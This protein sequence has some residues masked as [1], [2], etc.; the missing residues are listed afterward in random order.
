M[1]KTY[2]PQAIEQKWYEEWTASGVFAPEG[3]QSPYCIM[4]PPPNVTGS[5]H[6]GHG[7]QQT[8]MDAL[9]RYHRMQGDATL[10]Q[11]GTDH[12]GI[13]TQ[14]VVER[15]LHLQNQTRHD[16]G[17]EKFVEKVWDWKATSGGRI[18]EQMRRLGTSVDWSRERFT[19]DE[20]LSQAVHKVFV[21]LYDQG[22]IYRGKRLVNWDPV[23][24]TALSDLE[25]ISEEEEGFLWHINYPLSSGDGN[26]T[27]A[28]TRPETLLGDVAVAVHPEDSRYQHLIGHMIDL[29]LT[30]RKIPIIADDYVDP[31][32]GSGCVKITPA[33]DFNDYAIGQRH[34]LPSISILTKDAKIN[35]HAPEAYQ[36]L[37][38]FEA[39]KQVLAD[40]ENL[41]LLAKTEKH[42]LNVP[43]G[44]KSEVIVE[45]ML[46]DQWYVKIA[47]LAEPAI[48]AV[49]DG[50]IK[51]VP[52]NWTK[53][54]YQWMENIEDWCISRQLWWGHRIPAWYDENNNIY[55]GYNEKHIRQKYQ[56]SDDVNLKQD[57]DVLDT[58]FSS[59][60]WPFSTLG[61]PDKSEFIKAFYPT[62]V[63]VTGFDIIFFWVARMIMMGLK[64]TGEVPFREVYITGLIRDA[65][66]HKMSKSKGNVLDP[67]DI[68]DGIGLEDLLAKRTQNLV[69]GSQLDEIKQQTIDE[70]PNGINPH[71]TDALRFTYCAL[72]T[73]GR[74]IR[75]DM[76]RV[77][78]Y[79]NFCNKLWN[80]TRYV[81]MNTEEEASDLGD[82]PI[83]YSAADRWI[84]AELQTCIEQ[85]H[86][87]FK[88]YRFDLLC[89][90]LYDFIWR[91][92]CDWYLELSKP[93][94][95]DD[96]FM[97][98]LKRG[99]RQTLLTV[100]ETCLRLLHPM[101]PFITE[102]IWQKVSKV[103]GISGETI[104]TQPYPTANDKLI[105]TDITAQIAWLKH[106]IIEIRTIRSEMNIK[107][108][109]II[110]VYF[111]KGDANDKARVEQFKDYLIKLAK[112]EGLTWL[113]PNTPKPQAATALLHNLEILI[114]MAGLI[115]K[116][117]ETERLNREISKS[118]KDLE[119]IMGK[120][121][122]PKFTDKAPREVVSKERERAEALQ[123]TLS[124]L[125]AQ[126]KQIATL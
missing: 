114:P 54:Y 65:K 92:Y 97:P 117:A 25:V 47:P 124:K 43:R 70:F 23:L 86:A 78:G 68:I 24:H 109:K 41:R 3:E 6:M 108:S 93:I 120:L 64:F 34:E 40:L 77:E 55:V 18:T 105:D 26:I 73:Q 19:L 27:I 35:H 14:M 119:R 123:S 12:A 66:G 39:R 59:A 115:D 107:P 10:W 72:A 46:T 76:G 62:S 8:I 103:I 91:E 101:M 90:V 95:Y 7:F 106:A 37:D 50:D 52:D 67:L 100:L 48:K 116:A 15:Q 11:P 17:R 118:N 110:P 33:H 74:D 113:D 20:G 9:T 57:D 99:T 111:A 45:P 79:R 29:P 58:W 84:L 102:E 31:E 4:L 30:D 81:L 32:F 104:S 89:Q 122:N 42:K 49:Q 44:E 21:E 80:A 75:F 13:S 28:T 36:N 126:L 121:N 71:G 2:N 22:L 98:A 60:L 87:H 16:L 85:S 63:L 56:L 61:W 69:M 51:F 96:D 94:L 53:T 1:D 5:L 88:Q 83:E 112:C 125:N 82:G 38:R